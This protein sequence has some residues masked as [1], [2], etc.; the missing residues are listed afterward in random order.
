M[1]MQDPVRLVGG[2]ASPYT[3]KMVALLRY[4]RI[5]YAVTWGQ[6]EAVCGIMGVDA[7]RPVL[8]PTFFFEE[9]GA[10]RATV[11]STPII[12]RLEAMYP[13]RSVIPDDPA[14]AFIDYLLED[15]GDE[16]CTKYMFH[17]RWYPQAD[18]DNAGSL[19]PLGMD[20]TL[21]AQQLAQSKAFFSE[22]Q[23]GRLYVVGSN[24]TTAPVIDASYRRFLAAM[25]AHLANQKFLLGNRPGSGDFGIYGQL[26]QLVGFDPTPRAIAHE[27]SPRTV[28]WVDQM[29]DQCGLEPA[30]EDWLAIERQPGTLK[31]L[32]QE[33]GRVYAPAQLA[34]ARAV[35]AG[36]KTWECEIDGAAWTQQTFPYQAKC[37]QW[38]NE[39]YRS[40]AAGDRDRVDALLDGTGV[41]SMLAAT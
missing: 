18:A 19:L 22:R 38:T 7:P 16:W 11:D 8:M 30:G 21:P 28:A 23:I 13:G 41:E 36:D 32:L 29:A 20:V 12:R 15:F 10:L 25:E 37:L 33:V 31:G 9:E 35:Q 17:Y 1:S 26:T 3:Q 24:D 14:L 6:V 40:L 39:R 4:R 2:T 27:V 5:P 34:N